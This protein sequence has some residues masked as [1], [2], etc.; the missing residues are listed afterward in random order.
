MYNKR[1]E[2]GFQFKRRLMANRVDIGR[3][4]LAVLAVNM[5]ATV[6]C[7]V[8]RWQASSVSSWEAAD[9]R[10]WSFIPNWTSQTYVNSFRS[11]RVYDHVSDVIYSYGVQPWAD[12]SLYY[13]PAAANHLARL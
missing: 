7:R 5:L 4:L 2:Q 8:A 12:G 1:T 3:W 13:H 10:T 9:F 6:D 11:D